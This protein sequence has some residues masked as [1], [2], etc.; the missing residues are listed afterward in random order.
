MFCE[1][2]S[3]GGCDRFDL[4]LYVHFPQRK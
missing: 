3:V 4:R 2:C 1:E